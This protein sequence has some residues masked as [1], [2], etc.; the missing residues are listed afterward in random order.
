MQVL[1]SNNQELCFKRNENMAVYNRK[2]Y[3]F[4]ISRQKYQVLSS[5]AYLYIL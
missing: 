4:D 1:I 2:F 5:G 3:S